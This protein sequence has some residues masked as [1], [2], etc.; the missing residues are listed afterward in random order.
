MDFILEHDFQDHIQVFPLLVLAGTAFRRLASELGLEFSSHPPYPVVKTSAFSQE[1]MVQALDYAKDAFDR[2]F[3]PFPD[4][5]IS[6]ITP[7]TQDH[8][9]C[10][11]NRRLLAKL[12]LDNRIPKMI[13][14]IKR[15]IAI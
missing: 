2:T 10:P 12:V 6:F 5:E 7:G 11:D 8:Y 1:D 14:S 15:I 4:L 13:F 3:L 9:I